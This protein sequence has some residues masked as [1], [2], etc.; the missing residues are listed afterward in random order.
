ML[1]LKKNKPLL[2][3]LIIQL[4]ILLLA[5]G[6]FV[7]CKSNL[8]STTIYPNELNCDEAVVYG[9]KISANATNS[10]QGIIAS[11]EA[12]SLSRGSYIVY[13]NYSSEVD[14]NSIYAY[15]PFIPDHKFQSTELS[16]HAVDKTGAL[17]MRNYCAGDIY[18]EMKYCGTGTFEISEISV[19]ETTDMAKQDF[20]YALGLC[21][22][23]SLGY[24]I[25]STTLTKRKII[26]ALG[27]IVFLS[28]YP[29]LLD[30]IVAGHDLPFH[31]VRI[32]AIKTGI[33]NGV[34]P[35][36]I[37]PD[38]TYGY[39]YAVGVFYGDALLYFPALLRL[40]GIPVQTTY[41]I[42]V[43]CVNIATVLV[44]YYCY[45]KILNNPKLGL[46]GTMLYSLSLYRLQ[47]LYTR[48]SVG[49]YCAMIFLPLIFLGFYN[50]YTQKGEKKWWKNAII[51]TIGL[52]GIIH[53]H[54]LSCV[55]VAFF[56]FL[57][58]FV[59]IKRTVRPKV[60]L[61]LLLTLALTLLVNV[62]FIVPF[63]DYYFTEEFVMHTTEWTGARSTQD[64]GLYFY[65]IFSIFQENTG[66]S[67]ATAAGIPNEF[68]PGLGIPLTIG[69]FGSLYMLFTTTGKEKTPFSIFCFAYSALTLFMCSYLF[70]WHTIA[71]WGAIG[72]AFSSN[73]Q[74]PWRLLSIG[75]LFVSFSTCLAFN[76]LSNMFKDKEIIHK[77]V[78][79]TSAVV[80]CLCTIITSGWFYYSYLS[81]F[82]PYR[83]YET[84]ELPSMQIYSC[85]YLPAGTDLNKIVYGR[86]GA[87]ENIS[88]S[89]VSQQ[90]TRILCHLE[91][92]GNDG[93]FEV[94]LT[95]YKGYQAIHCET[96]QILEIMN[97]ENNCIRVSIP[98][99]F[100]GTLDISFHEPIYWRVAEVI[101]A[102]TIIGL[103]AVPT[104]HMIRAK[105]RKTSLTSNEKVA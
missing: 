29:L 85:E 56:I 9:E 16:L 98:S 71:N 92:N 89:S 68:N 80:L 49:E 27:T 74:F 88:V 38:W 41:Q 24:Y 64:I 91:N 20:I 65:Q 10:S 15:A 87:T 78:M 13:I 8:Y 50:I 57:T 93:Y 81:D 36:K 95:N 67:W 96:N 62:G 86:Y 6:N 51:P 39:G 75:T 19:H 83:A 55:M 52:T 31:L 18:L 70:P 99:G 59:L 3:I 23:L 37:H 77:I 34:F 100:N 17:L 60:L 90:G 33:S 42:F 26:F 103:I 5:A 46:L 28:S 58:C 63:V 82:D 54:I 45:N 84:Y 2:V 72:K 14:G 94:P 102:L 22:V 104:I 101:S 76:Q 48:G 73:I 44:S 7:L 12:L 69:F 53:T 40:F 21:I 25:Y 66:S 61:T 1:N 32:D 105:K 30:Y 11:T 79:S 35:V 47:N 97:G 43:L 4:C